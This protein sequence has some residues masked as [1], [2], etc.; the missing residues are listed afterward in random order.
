MT[1][2]NESDVSASPARTLFAVAVLGILGFIA[3]SVWNS[4][5]QELP[6]V[7]NKVEQENQQLREQLDKL[8]A[9]QAELDAEKL[10]DLE[11]QQVQRSKL[12][13]LEAL[14]KSVET[15]LAE[16]SEAVSSWD[17][18]Q[19][20]IASDERGRKIAANQQ[21]L[22]E[23]HALIESPLPAAHLVDAAS[24]KIDGLMIPIR[25]ALKADNPFYQPSETTV[26]LIQE[27]AAETVVGLQAYEAANK[28][29]DGILGSVATSAPSS[30]LTLSQALAH[31]ERQWAAEQNNRV[32]S[33]LKKVRDEETAKLAKLKADKE[34]QIA[35]AARLA[36]DERA[37][38]ELARMQAERTAAKEA[39]ARRIAELKAKAERAQ[40]ESD[41]QRDLPEIKRYL[42]P[43]FQSAFSQPSSRSAQEMTSE[44]KP[45]SL[46][47]LGGAGA[48]RESVDGLGRLHYVIVGMR[49]RD[50]GVFRSGYI[51]GAYN[52]ESDIET[53][54][55]AQGFLL[56]YGDLLVE[57][58]MLSQ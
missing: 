19:A 48:L 22:A 38:G 29:L 32:A 10:M 45:V 1:S 58:G 35:E 12:I 42:A 52:I 49:D 56:K 39:E 31:L 50:N 5:K 28:R 15:Q 54:R 4:S 30:D 57:K 13:E 21:A 37:A 55:K 14:G 6:E 25:E 33:E 11:N 41:F 23:Y 7:V 2:N 53:S 24:R 40:L 44:K 26:S 16:Y 46:T 27:I 8:I 9:K 17:K 34:R 36:E 43:L 3:Y 47:K 18:T 20:S 51:G